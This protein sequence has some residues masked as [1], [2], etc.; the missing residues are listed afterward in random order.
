METLSI[1]SRFIAQLTRQHRG[2]RTS[3]LMAPSR[4]TCHRAAHVTASVLAGRSRG[5]VGHATCGFAP[6][7]PLLTMLEETTPVPLKPGSGECR[8]KSAESAASIRSLRRRTR[9]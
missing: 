5:P 7:L 8:F 9:G 3:L 6:D 1:A 4:A 2:L